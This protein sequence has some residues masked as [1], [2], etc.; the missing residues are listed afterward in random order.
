MDILETLR[1]TREDAK[2]VTAG[3]DLPVGKAVLLG[4][5]E[6]TGLLTVAGR[7]G[8]DKEPF[9][10]FIT[11]CCGAGASGGGTGV[12]CKGCYREGYEE[13]GDVYTVK[14]HGRIL[15]PTARDKRI[16]NK[17]NRTVEVL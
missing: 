16:F 12:Y 8:E 1:Q 9:L 7:F 6:R 4:R 5:T 2:T 10:W 13:V 11:D 3:V 15:P 17:G 14:W